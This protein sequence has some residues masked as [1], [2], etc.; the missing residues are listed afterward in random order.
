[1]ALSRSEA[2]RLT[3]A[4]TL[5]WPKKRASASVRLGHANIYLHG[6]IGAVSPEAIG[7]VM[8]WLTSVMKHGGCLWVPCPHRFASVKPDSWGYWTE[9]AWTP[10]D[11]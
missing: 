11:E 4:R 8:M 6:V 1:M 2:V 7:R 10:P 5:G 3:V 9:H